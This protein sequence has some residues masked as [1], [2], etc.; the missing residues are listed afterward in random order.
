MKKLMLSIYLSIFAVVFSFE[1]KAQMA[2]TSADW[3]LRNQHAVSVQNSFEVKAIHVDAVINNQVADVN[4]SQTIKNPGNRSMEV[5][6]FFPLPNEGIVQNFTLMIDGEEVPGNLLPKQEA[7]AIYE[8]IVR[9]KRDPAL[10]EYVG[11]GLFKTSVFPIAVGEERVITVNYSQVLNKQNNLVEFSYPLG[12]QK[13][14]SN[15]LND[16]S[17]S[18]RLMNN[19]DIKSIFSPTN[20]IKINRIDKSKAE[21]SMSEKNILPKQDFKL[22]FSIDDGEVG[23]SLYSFK[24]E[25]NKAG[26]FMLMASPG[27][28]KAD[29]QPT[30]KNLIFVLDKSGSMSGKKMQQSI[31][32]LNFLM[33]NLNDGDYF[34]IITY[35]SRV[36]TYQKKLIKYNSSSQKEAK[37][38]IF[39]ITAGGGTNIND[40][41]L[42]G[43]KFTENNDRRPNYI[44]FLTVGRATSGI[45]SESGIINSIS[46]NNKNNARIFTFGVGNDVNARLLDRISSDN[47][48]TVEYVSPEEDIETA[49]GTLYAN[50]SNPVMTNIEIEISGTNIRETYPEK[51]PDIFEGGQLVWVGS[52]D[53]AGS[54]KVVITGDIGGTK[55]KFEYK[56]TFAK[57]GENI[58]NQYVEKIWASKRVSYLLTQIDQNGQEPELVEE[59][60]S[61]SK[62]FGILTPYTAFLAKEDVDLADHSTM[63]QKSSQQLDKLQQTSGSSA[64]KQRAYKNNLALDSGGG[65][66]NN[67][68]NVVYEFHGDELVQS[69]TENMKVVG[70]KTFYKRNGEWIDGSLDK[71]DENAITL[72]QFSD[73]FFELSKQNSAEMNSLMTFTENVVVEINGQVYNIVR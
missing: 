53:K 8:G 48:G 11:Y 30:P 7:T 66:K 5:E 12:T 51:L 29:T 26:Y 17:V 31:A 39:S 25:E 14:S 37:D 19:K 71:I 40:A 13:F 6:I 61:L 28:E 63:I 60:V 62:E 24:P 10:M 65:K 64:N 69:T 35:N 42:E 59:L 43:L 41:V 72:T 67:Q 22:S 15:A 20:D 1:T 58:Q 73:E 16:V 49:V 54:K 27:F 32:A 68:E 46:E 9:R 45:T 2:I 33:E 38:Y 34:N 23:A 50:I 44:L 18:V 52:Y 4:V 21:I 70:G 57:E 3:D 47:G 56:L 36:D 55:K